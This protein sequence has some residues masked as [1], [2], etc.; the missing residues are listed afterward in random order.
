MSAVAIIPARGGS[1]GLPRKNVRLICGKPLIA[2]TIEA[3]IDSGLFEKVIVS[4]DDAEIA[5][6]THIFGGEVSWRPAEISGDTASSEA[7]LLHVLSELVKAGTQP[8]ITVFLQCTSPLTTPEDIASTVELIKAKGADS[9]L[10]V[11]DFHYFLW[12]VDGNRDATGI[13]HDKAV[14]PLRQFREHQYIETGAVYAMRTEGFLREKHR[15]FGKTNFYVV[16]DGRTIEIDDAIDFEVAESLLR[17]RLD[18]RL[19]R[20]FPEIID[21]VVFDFDGVFTDD[22]VIVSQDGVESVVC[23]RSDGMGVSIAKQ[24]GLRM[25]ILSTEANPVVSQRAAKL[26]LEVIQGSNDKKTTLNGWIIANGFDWKR[27]IYVGND[28][29]DVGCLQAAGC[30]V[31]VANATKEAAQAADIRLRRAGGSHA[32]REVLELVLASRTGAVTQ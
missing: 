31:A 3:A 21:A 23:S 15:F 28:V 19:Y 20:R 26:G 30:G 4:T 5:Q 12:K 9:A 11:V 6:V 22:S 25:L 32:V 10:T 1:K 8:E 13:N 7:A 17:S 18:K 27:I 16:P 14:R 2:W 29:N 24:H